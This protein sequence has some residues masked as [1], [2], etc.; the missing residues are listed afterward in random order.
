YRLYGPYWSGPETSLAVR[1]VSLHRG[2]GLPVFC[3]GDHR[4]LFS[5]ALT[6]P[7]S[8]AIF[9]NRAHFVNR[10]MVVIAAQRP[11]IT[12]R[13]QES[14]RQGASKRDFYGPRIAPRVRRWPAVFISKVGLRLIEIKC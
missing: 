2:A 8:V 3:H 11:Q 9:V 12:K 5:P 7:H 10:R 14:Q 13:V 4:F 1:P 6:D